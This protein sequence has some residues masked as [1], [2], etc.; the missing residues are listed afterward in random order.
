[1]HNVHVPAYD[2]A[3]SAAPTGL[4]PKGNPAGIAAIRRA[5]KHCGMWKQLMHGQVRVVRSAAQHTRLSI[6]TKA[7]GTQTTQS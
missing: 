4:A 7:A 6:Y 1:M 5:R 2:I 3:K